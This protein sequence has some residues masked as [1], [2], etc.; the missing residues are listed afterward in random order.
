MK[1][2][3]HLIGQANPDELFDPEM[4]FMNEAYSETHPRRQPYS[5]K[6]RRNEWLIREGNHCRIRKTN[7]KNEETNE[8]PAKTAL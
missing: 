1:A 4:F 8:R 7:I 2:G 6:K 3:M 5:N